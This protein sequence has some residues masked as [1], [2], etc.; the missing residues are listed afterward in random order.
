MTGIPIFISPHHHITD[1]AVDVYHHTLGPHLV[2]FRHTFLFPTVMTK[3]WESSEIPL[4][5]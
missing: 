5:P 2:K 3:Y 1:R 4:N